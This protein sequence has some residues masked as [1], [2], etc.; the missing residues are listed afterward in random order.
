MTL[1]A[2]NYSLNS[3]L[4]LRTRMCQFKGLGDRLLFFRVVVPTT[5]SVLVWFEPCRRLDV[6]S[7]C[8]C[9]SWLSSGPAGRVRLEATQQSSW[10]W[11]GPTVTSACFR[12]DPSNPVRQ[13]SA[14]PSSRTRSRARGT[15]TG[16][17][18]IVKGPKLRGRTESGSKSS[19]VWIEHFNVVIG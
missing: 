16:Q 3:P 9:C 13:S 17:G 1:F 11:R 18:P 6:P 7:R 4:S 14:R 8:C 19:P 5:T 15:Y 12:T 2:S 10:L